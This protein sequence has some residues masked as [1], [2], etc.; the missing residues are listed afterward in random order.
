MPLHDFM[1]EEKH[2]TEMYVAHGVAHVKCLDC[3]REASKVFLTAPMAFVSPDIRYDSPI[4]GKAVTSMA[5]RREDLARSG[6]I[7]YDPC[8]KQ[9]FNRRIADNEKALEQ[10]VGQTVDAEMANM[11]ARKRERLEA[12][13]SGGADLTPERITPNVKPLK[14]EVHNG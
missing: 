1:C 13:L 2:V 5:A 8:M 4:D 9:D 10:A 12:E 7:P 3:G 14:V 6:C 11:P